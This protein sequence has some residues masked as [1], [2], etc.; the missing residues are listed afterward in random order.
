MCIVVQLLGTGWK[1][2]KIARVDEVLARFVA[3]AGESDAES[4][5]IDG[6]EFFNLGGG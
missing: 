5:R 6:C 2:G 3:G 1:G 4:G